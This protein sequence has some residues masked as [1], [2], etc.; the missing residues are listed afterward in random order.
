VALYPDALA[1]A[2]VE[3]YGQI[4]HFWRWEMLLARGDNLP[5]LYQGFGDV[6][7]SVLLTLL[8]ANRVYWFGWKWLD[9]LAARLRHA[10]PE[11]LERLRL[12]Y[13]LEPAEGAAELAALVEQTYDIVEREVPGADVERLRTIF[14]YRRASW[15]E[16]PPFQHS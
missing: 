6:V 12:V 9:T 2:A 8:A 3:R 11:L 7:R 14:R 4:D 16:P 15:D 5:M 1:V 13:R 10:P